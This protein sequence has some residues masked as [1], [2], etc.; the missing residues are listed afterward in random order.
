MMN[1]AWGSGDP[2]PHLS[3]KYY[4]AYDDHRYLKFVDS[5]NPVDYMN[6]SCNDNRGG[7]WPTIV[8]EFCISPNT[9]FQN[10]SSLD[11]NSHKQF[12]KQWFAAQARSYEKQQGWI[13][14]AWKAELNDYRWSY[15]GMYA[16]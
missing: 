9:R 12:Y 11:M 5:S 2:N 4:A 6:I 16:L 14:W 10:S 15:S 7:N 1:Q 3:N 13:F 8:G